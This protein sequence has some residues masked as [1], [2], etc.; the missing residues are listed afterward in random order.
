M[1]ALL[2]AVM[3]LSVVACKSSSGDNGSDNTD[4]GDYVLAKNWGE[5]EVYTYSLTGLGDDVMPVVGFGG[6]YEPS[7]TSYNGHVQP[8]FNEDYY[9]QLLKNAGVNNIC[10]AWNEYRANSDAI[11]RALDQAQK[12]GMTY[13]VRDNMVAYWSSGSSLAQGLTLEEITAPYINHPACAGVFGRDEPSAAEFEWYGKLMDE[14]YTNELYEGKDVYM[15]LLPNYATSAAF[16]QYKDYEGYVRGYM[17]SSE[18]IPYLAYDYYP[19]LS[20]SYNLDNM[21]ATRFYDNLSLI[22]SVANEYQIPFWV[23]VCTGELS[24]PTDYPYYPSKEAYMWNINTLLAYGMKGLQYY[25]VIQSPV[26]EDITDAAAD[27]VEWKNYMRHSF[28]GG[29]GNINRWYYYSVEL[30]PQLQAADEY[31]MNAQNLGVIAT[32]SRA[33]YLGDNEEVIASGTFR[34]LRSVS[35]NEAL[36]GCFDYRGSTMLYVVNNDIDVKQK[37]K[38]N[39][40]N[41]Y[42]YDVIQRGQTASVSG[43]TLTLTLEAGEGAL[44]KLRTE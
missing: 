16:G 18:H 42:G 43:K 39:F 29:M 37:I 32:G 19:F 22:R 25:S 24:N 31:L 44:V 33:K 3:M 28:I 13:F 34:E 35:A 38:L 14:I 23:F 36:V 21:N 7:G 30:T 12:F 10:F 8:N 41:N 27:S 17:A 26:D 5:V 15:N 9:W 40:D 20:S 2:C 6:P 1:M 4:P 11:M